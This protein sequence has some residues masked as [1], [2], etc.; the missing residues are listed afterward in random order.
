MVGTK[1]KDEVSAMRIDE[2]FVKIEARTR[3]TEVHQCAK[4]KW[5]EERERPMQR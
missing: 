4:F 5:H 2:Y 3:S 1:E